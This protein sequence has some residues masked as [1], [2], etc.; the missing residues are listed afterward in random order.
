MV[1]GRFQ[2]VQ[3][4]KF[5]QRYHISITGKQPDW[6][7]TYNRPPGIRDEL[8]RGDL[9]IMK[10]LHNERMDGKAKVTQEISFVEA[11]FSMGKATSFFARA[12]QANGGTFRKLKSFSKPIQML[13]FQ[14]T[15]FRKAM[16]WGQRRR[17]GQ[18]WCSN[19]NHLTQGFS[20]WR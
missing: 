10:K 7:T 20:V 4:Q 11:H 9:E 13:F 18:F 8:T 1:G 14:G 19:I 12:R 5:V 6:H 15:N 17:Q 2:A 16:Q 3:V